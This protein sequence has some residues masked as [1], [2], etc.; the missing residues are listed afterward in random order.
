MTIAIG[1]VADRQDGVISCKTGYGTDAPPGESVTR[2][3]VVRAGFLLMV[4]ALRTR[5]CLLYSNRTHEYDK[6]NGCHLL[7]Q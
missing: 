2:R 4:A 7:R 5:R 1:P 3:L 6:S